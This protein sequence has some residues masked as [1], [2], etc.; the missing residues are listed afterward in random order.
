MARTH[1]IEVK[2]DVICGD[3]LVVF[4]PRDTNLQKD[5]IRKGSLAA[6]L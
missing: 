5:V 4:L 1:T 3:L 6:L 2:L